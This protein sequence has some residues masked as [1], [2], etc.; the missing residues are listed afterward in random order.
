[1]G[2][3]LVPKLPL[4]N[5]CFSSSSLTWLEKQSFKDRV[6]KRELG[7]E[8]T[9]KELELGNEQASPHQ[10]QGGTRRDSLRLGFVSYHD[11]SHAPA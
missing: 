7:N 3:L 4:G 1:M 5:L 6:P 2:G 8:Q 10:G 11:R 9:S